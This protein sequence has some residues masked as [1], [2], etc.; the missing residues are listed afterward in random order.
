[1]GIGA[2]PGCSA[3]PSLRLSPN[4]SAHLCAS[5]FSLSSYPRPISSLYRAPGPCGVPSADLGSNWTP[6][7]LQSWPG[8]P[9]GSAPS[10]PKRRSCSPPW[11]RL[12]AQT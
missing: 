8:P 3:S 9:L 6:S 1:M 10:S 12:S 5:V 7:T 11:R 4:L 2:G